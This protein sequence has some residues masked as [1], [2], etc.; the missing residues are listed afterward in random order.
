MG[1]ICV[2]TMLRLSMI[3]L[4]VLAVAHGTKSPACDLNRP[5]HEFCADFCDG[6]CSFYNVSAGETGEPMNITMYRITPR[7]V[8]GLVNKNTADAPGDIT[9]VISKKNITQ[10][11]L[12]HPESLGCHT[13][14]E[15][16]DMYGQFIVEVDGQWG[17]YQMCNP[18]D[19]WD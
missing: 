3:S 4:A 12:K 1:K 14:Q 6:K 7:N 9:F 17:P 18:A 8:T 15:D 16:K 5:G 10:Q 2:S 19:G 13:D 11:C